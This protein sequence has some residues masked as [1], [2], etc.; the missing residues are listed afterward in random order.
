MSASTGGGKRSGPTLPDI[1][2][3]GEP[4]QA[5]AYWVGYSVSRYRQYHVPEAAFAA[6]L[7][8]LLTAANQ[9][10]AGQAVVP[11]MMYRH[12]AGLVVV[13]Q[14][15]MDMAVGT[16]GQ[17]K[18]GRRIVTAGLAIEVKRAAD[19]RGYEDDLNRL[20]GV[21]ALPG[22]RGLV[23]LIGERA[24]RPAH[25]VDA[26]WHLIRKDHKTKKGTTYRGRRLL[27]ALPGAQTKAAQWVCLL[28][29]VR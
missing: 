14:Q 11:E 21:S 15:R 23:V 16:L 6:E 7:W 17:T 28:E 20:V 3:L 26:N 27:K 8:A 29:A 1:K 18:K 19:Q 4:L 13:G 22:W 24:K 9:H 10:G 5:L 2:W 25:L 12:V